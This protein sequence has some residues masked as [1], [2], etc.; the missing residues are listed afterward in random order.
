MLI[1]ENKKIWHVKNLENE[2]DRAISTAKKILAYLNI[3]EFF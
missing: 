3:R 2:I 1:E